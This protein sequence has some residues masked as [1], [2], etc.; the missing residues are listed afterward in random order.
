ML[1]LGRLITSIAPRQRTRL[2]PVKIRPNVSAALTVGAA[3]EPGLQGA[4]R[5]CSLM[6]SRIAL[7]FSHCQHLGVDMDDVKA[8]IEQATD[9]AMGTPP[10]AP[11]EVPKP[12]MKKVR[13]AA[14]KVARKVGPKHMVGP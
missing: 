1:I 2:A 9:A 4:P 6:A 3:D 5:R 7:S 10:E 12:E 11:A 14:K 8:D 13:R